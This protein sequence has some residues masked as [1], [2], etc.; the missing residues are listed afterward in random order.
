[1]LAGTSVTSRL[2]AALWQTVF[3]WNKEIVGGCRPQ[4]LLP[5]LE[6]AGFSVH[7]RRVIQGDR[8]SFVGCMNNE[9]IVARPTR[10]G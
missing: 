6:E 1:M 4:Q 9:V 2:A 3:F 7:E 5:Y 8:K 10:K